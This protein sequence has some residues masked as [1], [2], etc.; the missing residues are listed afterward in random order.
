MEY[1]FEDYQ[2]IR[3][4]LIKVD[5]MNLLFIC[6][7]DEYDQEARMLFREM[8][9]R[10]SDNLYGSLLRI[11]VENFSEEM[12]NNEVRSKLKKASNLLEQKIQQ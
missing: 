8:R 9:K 3:K 12:I 5:P 10:K 11:F 2:I 4:I 6:P 7:E 1:T